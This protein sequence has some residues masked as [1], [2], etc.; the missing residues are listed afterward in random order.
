MTSVVTLMRSS[1]PPKCW[2]G[3]YSEDARDT[4]DA[5]LAPG[6]S[7]T[8]SPVQSYKESPV[9]QLAHSGDR[10]ICVPRRNGRNARLSRAGQS[11]TI[12]R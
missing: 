11:A 10:A 3:P 8:R 1:V 9:P 5:V 4:R 7:L 2:R 6:P 12:R